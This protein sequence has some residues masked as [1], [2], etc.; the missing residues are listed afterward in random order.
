[1]LAIADSQSNPGFGVVE[2]RCAL[3]NI[4]AGPALSVGVMFRFL[5]MSGYTTQ[6]WELSPM[7]PGESRGSK[8]DPLRIPIQFGPHFNQTDFSLM[9]GKLWEI[10]VIYQDIFGNWFYA[11]HEKRPLQLE[12]LYQ[13]TG[14]SDF[15]APS[16]PWVTFGK[17]KL[18]VSGER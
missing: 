11:V 8:E 2:I 16:Q 5:D 15:A 12:K 18:L 10:V 14:S 9:V 13:V 3:R 1:L 17:G 4:G 7:R 6:V